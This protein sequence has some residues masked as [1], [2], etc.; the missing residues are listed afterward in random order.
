MRSSVDNVVLS[1]MALLCLGA[2]LPQTLHELSHVLRQLTSGL[3]G[4]QR[5]QA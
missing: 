3:D 2:P 4:K 5:P 1:K